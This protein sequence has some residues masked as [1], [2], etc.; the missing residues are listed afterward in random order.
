MKSFTDLPA[1]ALT[2][3]SIGDSESSLRATASSKAATPRTVVGS[4]MS[5]SQGAENS[6]RSQRD[7]LR[8]SLC[9]C[10]ILQVPVDLTRVL[11][12]GMLRAA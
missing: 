1:S 3:I 5:R 2:Y 6:A 8:R 4:F 11:P 10:R 7:G 12:R 9:D